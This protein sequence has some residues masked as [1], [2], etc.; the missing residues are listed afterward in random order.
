MKQDIR[1]E[2][3]KAVSEARIIGICG[4]IRPDGDCVGSCM[5][6]YQY[7]KKEYPDKDVYVYFEDIPDVFRYIVD[8]DKAITDYA[9]KNADLFISLDCSDVERLGNGR[10]LLE[11]ASVTINIDHHISNTSF[12]D[13]NHYKADS[14]SAC[15]VLYELLEPEKIDYNIAT[16]LYTG[17]IHDTG[18]LKYS[19][20][21][22]RTME[23]AGDLIDKGISFTEIIDKSFYEKTYTQNLVLGR[24]L[25]ESK[26]I[27]NGAIIYSVASTE[28]LNEYNA[29][30]KDT[31]GVVNALLLTKG[32]LAAVFVYQLSDDEYK[33]SLRAGGDADMNKIAGKFGGGGHVKAAGCTIKGSLEEGLA[34][35]LKD[36]EEEILLTGGIS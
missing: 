3:W 34:V 23:I 8:I 19:N 33:V 17:L 29:D 36:L 9:D 10:T 11:K 31:E 15:E 1:K 13:I 5:A 18:V 7:I 35:L 25:L 20:T 16:S 2:V 26:L 22:K 30:K 14:S 32:V 28:L 21:S 24:C 4:H 12:A 6:M 27:A